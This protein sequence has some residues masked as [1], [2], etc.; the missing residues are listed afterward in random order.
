MIFQVNK[1]LC[2]KVLSTNRSEV[3]HST[4]QLVDKVDHI[5]LIKRC[6]EQMEKISTLQQNTS[7]SE[8]DYL[9][10]VRTNN[11]VTTLQGLI[12]T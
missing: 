1:L 8:E 12:L 11:H 10:V 4:V 7:R 2:S 6:K 3:S 9:R 5:K